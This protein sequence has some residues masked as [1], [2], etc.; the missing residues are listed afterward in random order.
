M[1]S[2]ISPYLIIYLLWVFGAFGQLPENSPS[3]SNHE[4]GYKILIVILPIIGGILQSIST[5][6]ILTIKGNLDVFFAAG[7]CCY[8]NDTTIKF[9]Y[10]Y[11]PFTRIE[12][13]GCYHIQVIT[14]PWLIDYKN[15]TT[16]ATWNVIKLR[17]KFTAQFKNFYITEITFYIFYQS[18][19]CAKANFGPLAKKHFSHSMLINLLSN[20][21]QMSHG[22]L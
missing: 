18:F 22:A 21:N 14:Y 4:Q 1:S 17:L 16:W 3:S 12:C 8:R 20:S 2:I 19:G 11:Q 15:E 7:I 9:V 10:L 5:D 6:I 13:F